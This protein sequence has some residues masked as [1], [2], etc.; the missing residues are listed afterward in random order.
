MNYFNRAQ[1][2]YIEVSILPVII[3]QYIINIER[4]VVQKAT[5]VYH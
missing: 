4:P 2:K 3:L 1:L 5:T